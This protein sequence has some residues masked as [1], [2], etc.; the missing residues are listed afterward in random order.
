[1]NPDQSKTPPPRHHGSRGVLWVAAGAALWGTDPVLRW[2]LAAQFRS[3]QIVL[4]EHII[5]SAVLL[6]V[7]WRLRAE[8]L[9]L[10]SREWMAILA[11][12]WG[13]SAM[14]TLFFTEAIRTGNPTSAVL[15]QKTQPLFAVLF[16]RLVLQERLGRAFWWH[17]ALALAA[18]YFVS[19]GSRSPFGE[20]VRT[21]WT[22]AA[23]AL[24]AAALWGASTV[25]G[26]FV[27]A[28][29]SFGAMTALRIVTATPLLVALAFAAGFPPAARFTWNHAVWLVLLALIPGLTALALYY[30]GLDRT[31][32]SVAALAE[33][34]FPA[35]AMLLN[36]IILGARVSVIQFLA[37][38]V[39]SAVIL[40]LKAAGK[41]MAASHS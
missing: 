4:A 11:V 14:A 18:S 34:S 40:H 31:P 25:F 41:P 30:K 39:L 8:W 1:V 36:W 16:A 28:R 37:F 27:L 22:S 32:A 13:G 29:I 26:R 9:R 24:N 6:P 15:L 19:F 38:V 21:E 35:T 23:L 10:G 20:V 33:L 7:L 2:P 17:A 12:S 3:S 5:L